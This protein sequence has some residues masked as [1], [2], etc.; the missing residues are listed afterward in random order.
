M[1]KLLLMV[2]IAA[3]TFTAC[4]KDSNSEITGKGTLNFEFENVVGKQ[5]LILGTQNYTTAKGESFKVDMFKYY[6]SN[7]ELSKA[8]GSVYKAPNSYFLIDQSD[9]STF[10]PSL[11]D[12][13]AGDY[14]KISFTIG[15]DSVSNF[16]GAQAGVLA[17]EKAM[18]WSWKSGYVFVKMEGT[19]AS[20][21]DGKL[22]FHIG[23][24]SPTVNAIRKV[25]FPIDINTLRIR[26]DKSPIIHFKADAGAMFSGK[27][28]ISFTQY[29]AMHGGA[30]ALII[31]DNYAQGMFTLEHIHN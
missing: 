17:P 8:D 19:S 1:K 22:L 31:A 27:Q 14:T 18:F 26:T 3:V 2:A 11:I 4:T 10:K 15:V 9:V 30:P 29:S 12:I 7:I 23:G 13:P 25:S 21:P 24:A 16:T 20:S 6:V 5:P 28:N